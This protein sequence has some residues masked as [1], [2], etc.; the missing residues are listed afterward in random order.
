MLPN[1][2]MSNNGDEKEGPSSY[3]TPTPGEVRI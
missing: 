3:L 1:S 2:D